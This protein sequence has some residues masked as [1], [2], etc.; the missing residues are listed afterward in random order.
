MKRDYFSSPAPLF[1]WCCEP[2]ELLSHRI[3]P[4]D[5]NEWPFF[6]ILRCFTA[7]LKVL[8]RRKAGVAAVEEIVEGQ[9]GV[10]GIA[11]QED[12]AA[13]ERADVLHAQIVRLLHHRLAAPPIQHF[14][15]VAFAKKEKHEHGPGA[16]KL[17][18]KTPSGNAACEYLLRIVLIQQSSHLLMILPPP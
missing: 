8:Q 7:A 1:G 15:Q 14:A 9:D 6:A 2:S 16:V 18:T 3:V 13:V 10:V 4:Q 12:H 11:Q 5:V 17:A